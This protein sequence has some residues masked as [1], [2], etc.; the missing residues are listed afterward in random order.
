MD[1]RNFLQFLGG[2]AVA[3]TTAT[4]TPPNI[5]ILKVK[6]IQERIVDWI[7]ANSANIPINDDD[8]AYIKVCESL[9]ALFNSPYYDDSQCA[10]EHFT[11]ETL[12]SFDPKT[13]SSKRVPLDRVTLFFSGEYSDD[14]EDVVVD[15]TYD[16][17]KKKFLRY[18][19]TT[20]VDGVEH[21]IKIGD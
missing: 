7:V 6:T 20:Y 19:E 12:E 10:L 8:N 13:F 14:A 17:L 11:G 9:C 21:T 1:R 16:L 3:S 4:V 15:C 2:A 5:K 18:E